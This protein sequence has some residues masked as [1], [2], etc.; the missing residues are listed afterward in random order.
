M[1]WKEATESVKAANPSIIGVYSMFSMAE[2]SVK[3]A[4]LFRNKCELLVAGGPLPTVNPDFF[5][6]YFDLVVRGEGEQTF[7]EIVKAFFNKDTFSNIQ[8]VIYRNGGNTV[9]ND[10]RQ[11]F[12][13]LDILPFPARDLFPN[14][15]Y[16]KY[17]RRRFKPAKTSIIT[18][19]GCPFDCDFCSH[20][21]FGVSYRERSAEN[22]VDEIEEALKL[23]YSSIFFVDDC[24][25]L[26]KERVERICSG[27]LERGLKFEWECL[28][29]VDNVTLEL[30]TKMK[31]AG[32]AR[33]FFGI[34]SG[35]EEMLKIIGKRFTLG[36]ARK[37]VETASAAGIKT[38][39]FFILGYPGETD[40][41]LLD[42][43]EFSTSLP[44]D[45]LSFTMP[46]PIPGTGLYEKVKSNLITNDL[47]RSRFGIIDHSLVYKSQYSSAK[48]KFAI[49]KGSF[50]FRVRKHL[51][52]Y[53][54]IILK[55]FKKV[56]DY[57]LKKMS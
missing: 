24:F 30:V 48:L 26:N 27:I 56:T 8:G 44:L 41:T 18:T 43:I 2:E 21:V 22:V 7:L 52:Q 47:R 17:W 42:T 45:Y 36:Q 11:P 50:E 57:I 28:S 31:Q 33:M 49:V 1:S 55:P 14:K 12:R 19:R 46:Y 32:C 25:T 16:V 15:D 37:T 20:A 9:Y 3:F 5:L 29:R 10:R 39:A 34:E 38:G 6:N 23:G 53:S 35:N 51:G 4:R 13:D 54:W 40:E